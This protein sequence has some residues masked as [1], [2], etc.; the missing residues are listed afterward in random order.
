MDGLVT[1]AIAV[2]YFVVRMAVWARIAKV[3]RAGMGDF[4]DLKFLGS[5]RSFNEFRVIGY[6]FAGNHEDRI[7]NLLRVVGAS[8][9]TALV[10]ATAY[11]TS[12]SGA[13]RTP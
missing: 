5:F 12:K 13:F 4:A 3:G 7:V 10:L 6:F 9:V 1:L 2:M 11:L 8:L